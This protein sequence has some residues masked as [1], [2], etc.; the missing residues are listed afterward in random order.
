MQNFKQEISLSS[1]FDEWQ[2][3]TCYALLIIAVGH[4]EMDL[5]KIEK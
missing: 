2:L 3:A 5:K 4:C 1:D